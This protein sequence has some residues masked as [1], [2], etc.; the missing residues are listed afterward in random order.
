MEEK[1]KKQKK[2]IL[3]INEKY[4]NL[5]VE[6]EIIEKNYIV[7]KEEY[8]KTKNKAIDDTKIHWSD[9]K[10][11]INEQ[12]HNITDT[13]IITLEDTESKNIIGLI[14]NMK[15]YLTN[16]Q[17]NLK[18]LADPQLKDILDLD[19]FINILDDVKNY[20]LFLLNK[21][22]NLALNNYKII[23]ECCYF[24]ENFKVNFPLKKGKHR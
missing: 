6:R 7:L 23:N 24:Y 9:I 18:N 15:E 5:K 8:L 14:V 4:Q 11:A 20:I 2:Y 13:N 10:K 19:H 21:N 12:N 1:Y 3:L 22:N 17:D 16:Y